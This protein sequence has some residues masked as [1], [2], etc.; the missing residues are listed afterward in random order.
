MLQEKQKPSNSGEKT[1]PQNEG[2]RHGWNEV[3]LLLIAGQDA[4][5][6][7]NRISSLPARSQYFQGADA[8]IDAYQQNPK[9]FTLIGA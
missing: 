3:G 5:D 4:Q 2:Q 6:L 7:R 9:T 1:M 8:A